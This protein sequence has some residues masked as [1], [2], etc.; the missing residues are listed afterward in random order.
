MDYDGRGSSVSFANPLHQQYSQS[1]DRLFSP[2]HSTNAPLLHPTSPKWQ[3]PLDESDQLPMHSAAY[4][5]KFSVLSDL[6]TRMHKGSVNEKDSN[7]NTV[8]HYS[9]E[10]GDRSLGCLALLLNNKQVNRDAQNDHGHS[11]LHIA[12]MRGLENTMHALLLASVNRELQD[13]N[14]DTPMHLAG[15][16]RQYKCVQ[17]LA[18]HGASTSTKNRRGLSPHD[19]TPPQVESLCVAKTDCCT[20]S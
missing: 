8:L 12:A 14:G 1:S 4:F 15:M 20:I 16:N 17:L 3:S 9:A 7:G 19:V 2:Q 13:A 18:E 5:G 11:A 10:G 6:L